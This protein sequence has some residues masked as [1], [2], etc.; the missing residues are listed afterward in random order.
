[1]SA[2]ELL[3]L[4]RPDLLS[5][6]PASARVAL[7][8]NRLPEPGEQYGFHFDVEKCIGCKCCVVACNEQ[9]ANPAEINWRRVGEIEGGV[10][11]LA[12]RWHLSMGCNHCVEP[13]CMLGC[14]VEAYTKDSLT[15]IVDHDPDICIGCQYCTW[16]CSYGVPQ[17]NPER[18]VV[19]KCDMCHSRLTAGAQPACVNACPSGAIAIEIVDIAAWRLSPENG[20]APGL[21]PV[22][23]SL[24]TTRITMPKKAAELV[25]AISRVDSERIQPEHAHASLV[26]LLVLIQ[27]AA[28]A[29]GTIALTG[30]STAWLAA[31][32]AVLALAAAPMHLGRPI[33]AYRAWKGWKTSWL[34]REVIA[35]GLFA[36][37]AIAAA[38]FGPPLTAAAACLAGLAGIYCSA[39]IYTVPA[40]PSWNSWLTLADFYL[41]AFTLG[42]TLLLALGLINSPIPSLIGLTAQ[43]TLTLYRRNVFASSDI[44]E[45]R[46][47]ALLLD[48]RLRPGFIIRLFLTVAA[49]VALP[50]FPSGAFLLA[51]M[52]ELQGRALF[53]QSVV[54][55]SAASA[56]LTPGGKTA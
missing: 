29:M 24:S 50:N 45:R 10:F 20:N 54:G 35:F 23:D 42:P 16:N 51:L 3:I 15:G 21:P 27:M 26:F 48:N 52:A 47:T 31:A 7:T 18:G 49:I 39:R 40:R 38:W 8:P 2:T 12:Q 28:G 34:S 9:N 41:T 14:P 36:K 30:G 55:K 17:F 33:H 22:T 46:S 25:N 5:I 53:F 19:G 44:L 37:A 32:V 13:S 4:S 43:F 56:F 11:P 6:V 1:M